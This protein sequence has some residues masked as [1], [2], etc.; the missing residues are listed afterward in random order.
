MRA[1][2]KLMA[3]ALAALAAGCLLPPP[4]ETQETVRAVQRT[5]WSLPSLPVARDQD[6]QVAQLMGADFWGGASVAADAPAAALPP[7]ELRWRVAAT[8]GSGSG[9]TAL[10]L[11]HDESKPAQHLRVGDKLPSG[12]RVEAIEPGMVCITLNKKRHRIGVETRD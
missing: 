3:L 4:V 5:E 6:V 12:H 9:A 2:P 10:V 7:E 1:D 11:F 8:Y